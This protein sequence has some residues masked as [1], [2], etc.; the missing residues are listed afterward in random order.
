MNVRSIKLALYGLAVFALM[1][2]TATPASAQAVITN[3]DGAALGI[4]RLGRMNPNPGAASGRLPDG[5]APANSG[6][7]GL[8]FFTDYGHGPATSG[9]RDLSWLPVRRL[10]RLG[11]WVIRGYADDDL[12]DRNNSRGD[13]RLRLDATTATIVARLMSLPGLTIQHDYRPSTSAALFEAIV[14]ITNT[15]AAAVTDVRY[16]RT[17]DWDIPPTEFSELSHRPGLAGRRR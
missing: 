17:M 5:S 2:I 3:G 15:T 6:V 12:R 7:R 1:T 8:S 13:R 16:N 10:R 4:D 9:G 14:T 11:Q